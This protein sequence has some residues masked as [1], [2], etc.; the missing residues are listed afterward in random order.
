[1]GVRVWWVS[2]T[3]QSSLEKLAAEMHGTVLLGKELVVEQVVTP[4]RTRNPQDQWIK[5]VPTEMPRE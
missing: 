5:T 4:S 1:M 2:L 3:T